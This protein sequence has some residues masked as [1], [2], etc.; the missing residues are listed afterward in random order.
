MA[1]YAGFIKNDVVNGNGVCVSFFVQGCPLHCKGC[2]NPEAQDFSG[3]YELPS[4]YKENIISAMTENGILR[5]FSLLGGEPLCE[6][7]LDLSLD[8]VKTVREAFG[9]TVEISVW[10]GYTYESLLAQDHSKINEILKNID[11][12]IDGA[13]KMVLRDVT[14]KMRGS[15]NQRVIDVKK[16]LEKGDV[17]LHP[18]HNMR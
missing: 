15:S 12:L 5:N 8:V 3:G 10:S 11:I 9:D 18:Y 1:R 14:L 2:Q 7:N 17:V 4:N 6:E 16:S 13:F